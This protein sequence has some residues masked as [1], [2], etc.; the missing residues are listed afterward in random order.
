MIPFHLATCENVGRTLKQHKYITTIIK[1][2]FHK[3]K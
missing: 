3:Y 2:N 1:A